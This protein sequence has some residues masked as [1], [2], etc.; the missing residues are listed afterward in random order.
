MTLTKRQVKA[1]LDVVSADET[2]PI[3]CN[4]MISIFEGEPYLMATNSYKLAALGLPHEL[5]ALDGLSISRESLVR[6]YKLA[7]NKD[8]FTDETVREL[9]TE[10][11]GTYPEWQQFLKPLTDNSPRIAFNAEYMLTMQ[12]LHGDSLTWEFGTSL[13]PIVA[14]A[15]DNIYLVM[16]L[17]S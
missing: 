4:A 13:Q 11:E 6:W 12:I 17:R 14:Y 7:E 5:V 8:F 3:L 2:R 10:L 1:F 16:P 9:A 15:S